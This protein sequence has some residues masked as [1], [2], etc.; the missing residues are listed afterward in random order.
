MK[1][2]E[3]KENHS[4]KKDDCKEEKRFKAQ[5]EEKFIFKIE[6]SWSHLN[7]N[8][9]EPIKNKGQIEDLKKDWE[10]MI[11]QNCLLGVTENSNMG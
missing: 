10:Q 11:G 4:F 8:R 3:N 9:T 5:T 6:D 2:R 1:G 7:I